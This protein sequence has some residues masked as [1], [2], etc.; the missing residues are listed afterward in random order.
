MINFTAF[1]DEYIKIKVA[2]T[3]VAGGNEKRDR[4]F[5]IAKT[6][7]QNIGAGAVGYGLGHGV[8]FTV[9]EALRRSSLY[10][11]KIGPTGLSKGKALMSILGGTAGV[12]SLMAYN[13][14]QRRIDNAAADRAGDYRDE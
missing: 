7:A 4:M 14:A 13:A 10:P 3:E 12:T 2:Q 1:C 11:R 8:G 9:A 5:R 6:L